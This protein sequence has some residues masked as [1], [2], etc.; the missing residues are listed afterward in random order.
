MRISRGKIRARVKCELPISFSE[1]RISA[2]GGLEIF[3]RFLIAIDLPARLRALFR[4]T[5]LDADYGATRMVMLLV[6]L[7]VIGVSG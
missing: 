7:L 2:R 5:P 3:R 1:E 6:G 4:D